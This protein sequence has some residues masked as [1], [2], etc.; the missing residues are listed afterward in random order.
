MND[1]VWKMTKQNLTP[2]LDLT[3]YFDFLDP[4]TIRLKGHR[5]NLEHVLA[6]YLAGYN[7]D[8]I[9]KEFPGLDLEIIYAA[10]TYY[11]ANREEVEAYLERRR[12]RDEHAYQEWSA[13]PSPIIQRL[14]TV[15]EQRPEYDE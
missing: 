1:S 15:R 14:R 10:I 5:I 8:E 6:Y 11:L 2:S 9:A 4:D 12:Q 7:P 13:N 3:V